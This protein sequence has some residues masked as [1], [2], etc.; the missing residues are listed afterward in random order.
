MEGASI[1]NAL[2]RIEAALTRI[3]NAASRVSSSDNQLAER[4]AR[5][6]AA[7]TTS[8]QQLDVLLAGQRP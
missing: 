1:E 3:E 4:H 7:V 8:L 2:G 5:L 6:R